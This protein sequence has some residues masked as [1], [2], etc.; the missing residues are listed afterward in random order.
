MVNIVTV[1]QLEEVRRVCY[2]KLP[3]MQLAHIHGPLCRSV[4]DLDGRDYAPF[5]EVGIYLERYIVLKCIT[6]QRVRAQEL[7]HRDVVQCLLDRH[8]CEFLVLPPD[9]TTTSRWDSDARF[10]ASEWVHVYNKQ[11]LVERREVY[12]GQEI[13]YQHAELRL[14]P[15]HCSATI[16][17]MLDAKFK[18]FVDVHS[19]ILDNMRNQV[20][21]DSLRTKEVDNVMS[22]WGGPST[23]TTLTGVCR[24]PDHT[25]IDNEGRSLFYIA[26]RRMSLGDKVIR[27]I[28]DLAKQSA[29]KP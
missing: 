2:D 6:E 28:V 23:F 29:L 27:S 11:T 20:F 7:V 16:Q 8:M 24:Y 3:P 15:E 5:D 9:I 1:E 13:L 18:T 4:Y 25:M 22:A 12:A 14:D 26:E 17:T 19:D 10:V 21:W